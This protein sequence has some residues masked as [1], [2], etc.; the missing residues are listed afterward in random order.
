MIKW[1]QYHECFL[2]ECVLLSLSLCVIFGVLVGIFIGIAY[3]VFWLAFFI[4]MTLL[5]VFGILNGVFVSIY[6]VM[7]H[8]LFG[9]VYLVFSSQK[10]ED[11]HLYCLDKLCSKQSLSPSLWRKKVWRLE[12]KS[13][14][15]PVVAVG[16]DKYELCW[17][18][19]I[20]KMKGERDYTNEILFR[21]D[22][23]TLIT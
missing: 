13:M 5:G 17:L 14:I 9:M 23:K 12:E 18:W 16:S 3:L 1:C 2:L 4:G 6:H 22:A 15:L 11:L 20:C 8:L 7:K 19:C 10:Y 21:G